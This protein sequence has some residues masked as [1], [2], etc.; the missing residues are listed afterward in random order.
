MVLGYDGEPYLR[1]GPRGLLRE[2]AVAGHVSESDAYGHADRARRSRREPARRHRRA[3]IGCRARTPRSGTTTASTTW[4]R[5]RRSMVQAHP[6]R[7]PH[8][9]SAVDGRVPLRGADRGRARA[10]R[11]VPGPSGWSWLPLVAALFVLGFFVARSRPVR[12]YDRRDRG[13]HR[14]RLRAHDQRGGG[15]R[16]DATRP[17][18]CS[19]SATTSCRS[20]VWVVGRVTIWGLRRRRVEALYGVLLVGAMVGLVSG[21]TDLSYLWKSQLPTV[22]P[23]ASLARGRRDR[24]RPRP[25]LGRGRAASRCVARHL[26]RRRATARDPRWLE[27][28]VAG[29]DDDAVAV[30]CSRLDA[31]E[32][33]PL[34]LADRRRPAGARRRRLGSEALVFVVLAQD[35]IGSHVWSITAAPVGSTGLRVQRG[36]PAPARAELRVTFPGVPVP[37]RRARSSVDAGSGR[38]S[39]RRRG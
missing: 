38:R 17:R 30:E 5:R 6:D 36:T 25:R 8:D 26:A 19:S 22:G 24:L 31:A 29:L 12:A 39:P 20:I 21:L 33:I 14:R 13:A 34:A 1:V 23:D 16:R 4:A 32:V 11:W 9:R 35:E 37:A 28:L 2:P 3:G 10:A 7:L 15:A 18:P 27:R